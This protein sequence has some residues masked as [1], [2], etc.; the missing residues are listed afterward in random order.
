MLDVSYDMTKQ[1]DNYYQLLKKFV[2]G[3]KFLQPMKLGELD[4]LIMR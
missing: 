2:I 4:T 1:H 3:A